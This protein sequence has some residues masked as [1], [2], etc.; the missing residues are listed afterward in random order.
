MEISAFNIEKQYNKQEIKSTR[1]LNPDK[2]ITIKD[3]LGIHFV[4]SSSD[5][6]WMLI[7]I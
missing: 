5:E 3:N 6:Q 4:G 7:K 2:I 1:C